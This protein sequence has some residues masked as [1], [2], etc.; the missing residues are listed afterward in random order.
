MSS[1]VHATQLIESKATSLN[2]VAATFK[3][4][5]FKPD[6]INL[7]YGGGRYDKA[8]DLLAA[9]GCINAI[10]DPFNRTLSH[11]LLTRLKIARAG[12]AHSATINNVLNVIA[13]REAQLD[14]ISQAANGLRDDG[15]AYFLIHEGDRCGLGKETSKGW[16]RNEKAKA[17]MD[18]LESRFGIVERKGNILIARHPL[19][20]QPSLFD[21]P[22]LE[23][24]IMNHAK[25]LGVP[26]HSR[27]HG[28][29]K[30]IGGCLYVHRSAW[31]VLPDELLNKAMEKLPS[32][33]QACIAKWDDKSSSIS[34][35]E[36][37]EFDTIAEPAIE[38][39]LKV[40]IDGTTHLTPAKS[41]PQI[42]H[43][44]WNFVRSNY[45]GFDFLQSVIRSLQWA[46]TPCDRS[47][48]GTRSHWEST[49]LHP[50]LAGDGAVSEDSKSVSLT[51][52]IKQKA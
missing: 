28:V 12:G 17:Y 47:R 4:F 39:A 48:I 35:I 32:D 15:I 40:N 45:T 9:E 1:F 25:K 20:T 27:K 23:A 24:E 29:G 22:T 46:Q 51:K 50:L 16:Q 14:A 21:L 38:R 3:K 41:D 8:T 5:T 49:V 33:F 37:R 52:N 31:D 43:H 34:F 26:V 44:K 19:K 36:S 42:Y 11:N 6:T 30:S 18:L 2:Q 13:E 7:D 10:Y